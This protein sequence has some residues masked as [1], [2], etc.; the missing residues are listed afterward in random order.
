[1]LPTLSP[2]PSHPSLLTAGSIA[3]RGALHLLAR[4]PHGLVHVLVRER[5]ELLSPDSP[6]IWALQTRPLR[7][8]AT[9]AKSA[10]SLVV[11]PV[12]C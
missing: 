8:E 2:H 11:P 6:G 5:K 9:E 10:R 7:A 1:M 4:V 3:V 12:S